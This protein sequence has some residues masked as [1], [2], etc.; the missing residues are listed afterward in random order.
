MNTIIFL[1]IKI[2]N[3]GL[4]R[5]KGRRSSYTK[6]IPIRRI[7]GIE[8]RSAATF[9]AIGQMR[10][11]QDLHRKNVS[12]IHLLILHSVACLGSKQKVGQTANFCVKSSEGSPP[13]TCHDSKA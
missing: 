8:F 7:K 5:W 9:A 11:G 4:K 13:K 6:Y 3:E 2:T 12:Y 10:D 1:G